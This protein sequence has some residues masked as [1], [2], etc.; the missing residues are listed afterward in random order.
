MILGILLALAIGVGIGLINGALIYYLS[1]VSI[2]VT[3]S[4]QSILFGGLMY[5]SSGRSIYDLP[6]WM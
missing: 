3:I 4:M 6:E 1:I 5:S 2:I